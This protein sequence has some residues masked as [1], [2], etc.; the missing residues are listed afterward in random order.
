M[1][2]LTGNFSKYAVSLRIP[3]GLEYIYQFRIYFNFRDEIITLIFTC[4]EKDRERW[5]KIILGISE[6]IEIY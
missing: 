4:S 5:E 6:L 3:A 2:K 1:A